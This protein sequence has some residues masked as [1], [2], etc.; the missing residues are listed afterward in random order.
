[1]ATRRSMTGEL[2]R[3][4]ASITVP[5]VMFD[6]ERRFVFGNRAFEQLVELDPLELVG[7][8]GR[9]H[10]L[11]LNDP[12]DEIVAAFCPPPEVFA[13]QTKHGRIAW[14]LRQQADALDETGAAK[15]VGQG[16]AAQIDSPE[17]GQ[18]LDVTWLALPAAEQFA[19][20]GVF[21]QIDFP[22][23][24]PTFEQ[25]QDL[26]A[27]LGA[28]REQMRRKYPLD[29]VIG[30]HPATVKVR[31]QVEVAAS[32]DMT[33]L[34]IAPTFSD[35][36]RIA[37]SIFYNRPPLQG[38]LLPLSCDLLDVELLSTSLDSFRSSRTDF[39]T[40][41]DVDDTLLFLDVDQLS[42]ECQSL[43]EQSLAHQWNFRVLATSATDLTNGEFSATLAAAFSTITIRVL[44]LVERLADVPLLAQLFLERWN[45]SGA[46]KSGFSRT[47][48]DY[49]Q[50]YN[51]PG[52]VEELAQIVEQSY[53]NADGPRIEIGDL[54]KIIHWWVA[55]LAQPPEVQEPIRLDELLQ[56]IEM[57]LV[58]KALELSDGNKAQ[59][60]RLLG[61]TRMRVIRR[62][63]EG[64][65]SE[66]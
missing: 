38:R 50:A 33:V 47:A 26:H 13:G 2:K 5:V 9:F 36:E 34:I 12:L 51:W 14:P 7:R 20:V 53:E 63:A 35:R 25:V 48:T 17:K 46:Q 45:R 31:Q 37:R 4:F 15:K 41:D 3:M 58:K 22:A 57:R 8:A 19:I 32:G 40:G 62:V 18:S 30:N 60:A 10:A 42:V 24:D 21:L 1:M 55:D 11:P 39:F 52:D 16:D 44:P 56:S 49:L 29:S 59:A 61:I 43:L 54:P 28:F 66:E 65:K 23:S 6:A 27:Q 64:G